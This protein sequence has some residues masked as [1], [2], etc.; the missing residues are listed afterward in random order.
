MFMRIAATFL[1]SFAVSATGLAQAK[2]AGPK[3]VT[4]DV[5]AT[6]DAVYTG[7]MEMTVGGGKVT[8]DMK[9]SSPTPITGKVAGTAKGAALDLEFPYHMAEN[10]CDGTVRMKITLPSK[11]GPA[12]G[13]LE[14]FGCGRE[15]SDKLTGTVEL[16]PAAP[17]AEGGRR[18]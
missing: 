7:T 15:E 17:A 5:T 8:G 16:K 2:P 9:I 13:T 1:M 18:R 10:D 6:V 14:A 3:S 11:P 12:S 4:Y